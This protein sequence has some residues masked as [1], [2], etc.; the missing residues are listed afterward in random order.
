MIPSY[1]N[2]TNIEYILSTNSE[3]K[4]I[5]NLNYTIDYVIVHRFHSTQRIKKKKTKNYPK[6]LN[7]ILV[8]LVHSISYPTI[9]Q[10]LIIRLSGFSSFKKTPFMEGATNI[11]NNFKRKGIQE[12]KLFFAK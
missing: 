12:F 4:I 6:K 8:V 5:R 10:I 11:K 2:Y 1:L 7:C 3:E 9:L